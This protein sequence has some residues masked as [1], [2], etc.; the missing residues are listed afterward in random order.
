MCLHTNIKVILVQ[1]NPNLS[2]LCCSADGEL[3]LIYKD[4]IVEHIVQYT[5]YVKPL[6]IKPLFNQKKPIET[7]ISFSRLIWPYVLV[8][9]IGIITLNNMKRIYIT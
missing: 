2:L 8:L 4:C 9:F 5:R 7:K 1:E 6:F 3:I